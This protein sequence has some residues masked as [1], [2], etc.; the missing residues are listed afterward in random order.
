MAGT[1]GSGQVES[2]PERRIVHFGSADGT[3]YDLPSAPEPVTEP[4]PTKQPK[5]EPPVE[6][7]PDPNVS[8]WR[9][10]LR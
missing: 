7:P 9:R 2:D 5:P 3:E 1:L 10:W 8:W 6:T 4:E